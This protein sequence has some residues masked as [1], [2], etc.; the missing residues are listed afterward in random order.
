[1]GYFDGRSTERYVGS[2]CF[3]WVDS[4]MAINASRLDLISDLANAQRA[5]K[6]RQG[7]VTRIE[8]SRRQSDAV[9]AD[10]LVRADALRQDGI[11]AQRRTALDAEQA[12]RAVRLEEDLQRA[13]QK[14]LDATD[15]ANSNLPRGSLIDI[16][17]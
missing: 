2:R 17:A 8:N 6:T 16:L 5:I 15:R 12:A 13:Y 9:H 14:G 3:G 10:Q 1:M 7:D 11:K 4:G